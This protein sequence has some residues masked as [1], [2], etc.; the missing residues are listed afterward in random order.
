MATVPTGYV[1]WDVSAKKSYVAGQT[2]PALGNGDYL[3]PATSNYDGYYQQYIYYTSGTEYDVYFTNGW[4]GV[5]QSAYYSQ[6]QKAPFNSIGDKPVRIFSYYGCT[7]SSS[8]AVSGITNLWALCYWNCLNLTTA[9]TLPPNLKSVNY[10]FAKTKITSPPNLSG[11]A[12]LQSAMYTFAD[13]P[14]LASPPDIS[15]NSNLKNMVGMFQNCPKLVVPSG[16]A[17]PSGSIDVGWMF[18][19][20]PK[21]VYGPTIPATVTSAYA[22][23]QKCTTLEGFVNVLCAESANLLYLF[24]ET[25]KQIILLG[26]D[27]VCVKAASSAENNNVFAG[28]KA[29]PTSFTAIRCDANGNELATGRYCKLACTFT[30]PNVQNAKILP[31]TL[32]KNGAPLTLTW[33]LNSSTGTAIT[34]SGIQLPTS[35]KIVALYELATGEDAANFSLKN[36]TV[37]STYSWE[38]GEILANLTYTAFLIDF[39]PN[40]TGV[41]IGKEAVIPGLEVDFD[42]RFNKKVLSKDTELETLLTNLG[43]TDCIE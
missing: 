10:S 37:Y 25:I 28:I 3:I 27:S 14:N 24:A 39:L 18:Y 9:P 33:R 36:N 34:S 19:N 8:P 43:W 5:V 31:P 1:F 22:M 29:I 40:G 11:L 20:C 30:A 32:K 2:M 7:F 6:V 4:S 23:Y 12:N 41:A 38:S 26:N 21:V 13:C 17:L 42:S 16:Y 35:G 15:G